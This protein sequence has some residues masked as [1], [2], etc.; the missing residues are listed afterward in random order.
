MLPFHP[1]LCH[2]FK[3]M[4]LVKILPEW[5]LL[6][7][8]YSYTSMGGRGKVFHQSLFLKNCNLYLDIVSLRNL[9][10]CSLLRFAAAMACLCFLSLSRKADICSLQRM[11]QK[12]QT[13][14]EK[15]HLYRGASTHQFDKSIP[16]P[17]V[18]HDRCKILPCKTSVT[19]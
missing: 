19:L 1:V 6:D 2:G 8:Q 13:T 11:K 10:A 15:L 9:E 4:S 3:A 12:Y 14:D 18:G 7:M 17:S 16:F 5:G